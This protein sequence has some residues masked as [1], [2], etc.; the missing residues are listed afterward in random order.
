MA[1]PPTLELLP[2][3]QAARLAALGHAL[4][5]GE[6]GLLT[7]NGERLDL[8]PTVQTFLRTVIRLIVSGQR[9]TLFP[10]LADRESMERIEAL[11]ELARE[12]Y[13]L[14][15]YERNEPSAVSQGE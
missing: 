2:P 7:A 13:A 5:D 14:G 4:D 6:A 3:D 10:A 9:V 1:A 15:L 11:D 12:A 8:P